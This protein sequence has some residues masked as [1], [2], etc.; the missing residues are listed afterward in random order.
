MEHEHEVVTA[1]SPAA[2]VAA[3][4]AA[5]GAG[6]ALVGAMSALKACDTTEL[7]ATVNCP[8]LT[9]ALAYPL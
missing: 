6:P 7:P 8:G 5:V 4:P 9:A 2:P 1:P 3:T